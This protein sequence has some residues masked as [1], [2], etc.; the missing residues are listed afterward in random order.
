VVK[1]INQK[2]LVK[3][4]GAKSTCPLWSSWTWGQKN[5]MG[6]FFTEISNKKS[7]EFL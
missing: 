4:V 5:H 1:K 2:D 7:R 3:K 6:G